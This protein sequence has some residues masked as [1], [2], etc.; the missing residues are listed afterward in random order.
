MLSLRDMPDAEFG[1]YI[2]TAIADYAIEGA[3]ATG[4][5]P[6]EAIE[7]AHAQVG[8]LLPEGC[9]TPGQHLRSLVTEAGD[10]IGSLWYAD[11][12]EDEPPCVFLYDIRVAESRRGEGLGTAAMAR[13]EDEA[14][15]LGAARVSCTCFQ[16]QRGR[17]SPL[18]ADWV[19]VRPRGDGR[20]PHGKST[21][22]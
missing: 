5:P 20:D 21:L 6:D 2:E 19:P 13:L 11:Q 3:R 7:R 17:D 9:H 8:Q 16:P 1:R 14:R 15:R 12:C 22:K 4:T 18:R 10:V